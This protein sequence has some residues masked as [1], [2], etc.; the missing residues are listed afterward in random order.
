MNADTFIK[1]QI[2]NFCIHEAIDAGGSDNVAA[3]A[4]V[5]RNRVDAG[6]HGGDW[7]HILETAPGMRGTEPPPLEHLNL[8]DSTVKL[9]LQR[10]DDIYHG[11]EDD[12]THGAVFYGQL[13]NITN[14]WFLANI[15]RD[16][17]NH[18]RLANIGLTTFFG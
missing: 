13:H 12:E 18:P 10:I 9:F 17:A 4:F 7:M 14:P 5:L 3:I 8:R 15:A 2:A 1:G 11:T 6:W 16:P